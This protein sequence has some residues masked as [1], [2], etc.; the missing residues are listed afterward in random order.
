MKQQTID[1]H[2]IPLGHYSDYLLFLLNV[3]C[4]AKKSQIE[5]LS[6]NLTHGVAHSG[7]M[8]LELLHHR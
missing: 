1:G 3:A 8:L 5:I 6:F 4:L 2:V 7:R